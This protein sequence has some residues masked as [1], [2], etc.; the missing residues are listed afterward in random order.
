[1]EVAAL[2]CCQGLWGDRP[3]Q[4]VELSAGR[5]IRV[6]CRSV[7]EGDVSPQS[8]EGSGGLG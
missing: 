5:G 2:D 6:Y 3:P 4:G 8:G 1:M 7:A